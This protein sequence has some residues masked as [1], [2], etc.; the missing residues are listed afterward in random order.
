MDT[1]EGTFMESVRNKWE[2]QLD[3]DLSERIL[4]ARRKCEIFT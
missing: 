4:T 2:A 3:R 1:T